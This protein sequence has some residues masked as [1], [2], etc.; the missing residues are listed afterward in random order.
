M[1]IKLSEKIKKIKID[2]PTKI[3]K[4]LQNVLKAEDKNDQMKEHFWGI[5]FNARMNIIKIEL[6]SLGTLDMSIIHPREI[7]K[8]AIQS[9]A[10]SLIV[11]HNHPSGAVEPSEADLSVTTRLEKA[12]KIIGI[13]LRDHIIIAKD[14][15][16]SFKENNNLI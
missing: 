10:S 3:A 1:V 16:Y 4:V 11:A 14:K 9:S 15:F 2:E 13:E 12:G 6:I 7:Y 8:P 5:Y